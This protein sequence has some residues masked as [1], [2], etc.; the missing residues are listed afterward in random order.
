MLPSFRDQLQ[1]GIEPGQITLARIG[2][3]IRRRVLEK[4]IEVY[5]SHETEPWIAAFSALK[6]LLEKQRG[7]EA[8]IVLS[9]Q[10]VRYVVVPWNDA[11]SNDEEVAAIAHHRFNQVYGDQA[12]NREVRVSQSAF[13]A[14]M[15]ACSME[16]GLLAGLRI[17]CQEV[18]VH[19]TVIQPALMS[20][21]NHWC[22]QV[23]EES[24]W[25]CII[26][27]GK[28]LIALYFQGGWHAIQNRHLAGSTVDDLIAVLDRERLLA[29]V[30]DT[31][32][33]VFLFS[34]MHSSYPSKFG[35]WSITTMKPSAI[36]GFSPDSAPPF[37]LA[38]SGNK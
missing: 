35:N 26:E 16:R 5:D 34:S 38:L 30:A 12:S 25:F 6:K 17:V 10:F 21:F 15:L 31:P 29:D 11:V 3:G 24:S 8:I 22:D 9:N 13:G 37:C 28:L 1:I 20:V 32:Q 14:P 2:K 7:A 18:G 4:H 23:K 33:R 19:L 36:E 27:P